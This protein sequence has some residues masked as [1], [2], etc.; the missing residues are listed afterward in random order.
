MQRVGVLVA[1]TVALCFDRILVHNIA[2]HRIFLMPCCQYPIS[3]YSVT[4]PSKDL[5]LMIKLVK[6]LHRLSENPA[7]QA[8]LTGELPDTARFNPGHYGVMMGYD[9][10]LTETGPKL[11]EVNTNAGGYWLACLCRVPVMPVFAGRIA[12]RLLDSFLTEYALFQQTAY[13]RPATLAIVDDAPDS[14]FLYPEMQAFAA[15]FDAAGIATAIVDPAELRLQDD[16]LYLGDRRIDMIYN[17]HCDFYLQTP[18]MAAVKTAWLAKRVCLTP[19]PHI[20]GLLADKRRMI[21]W[22]D[23]AVLDGLGLS[24]QA[25]RLL[26]NTV[27]ATHRLAFLPPEQVLHSRKQWVF[28]P[29]TGYASRGVY[30]GNKLTATKLAQLDREQTLI[31]QWVPPSLSRYPDELPFKTDFRLFAYRKQILGVSARLYHG[32][33]TN[34]RTPDGGFARVVVQHGSE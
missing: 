7:Y 2:P 24:E 27:P 18:A 15:L 3:P 16:A 30:V 11:I 21:A 14:Q 26:A 34:L 17:R 13:A 29:D 33:V 31:Q 1:I 10:H 25:L 22:S 20:Y 9:F 28:K 23:S 8:W 19:N 4:L 6:L 5:R 32:Q 12:T